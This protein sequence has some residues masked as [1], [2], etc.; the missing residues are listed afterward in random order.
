M[1]IKNATH[2]ASQKGIQQQFRRGGVK[3]EE[4][5]SLCNLVDEKT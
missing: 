3:T 1:T 4:A 2:F 5:V